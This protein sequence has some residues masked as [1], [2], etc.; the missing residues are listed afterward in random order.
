M[1]RFSMLWMMS[2]SLMA[3]YY[4]SRDVC[5]II[6]ASEVEVDARYPSLARLARDPSSYKE[7]YHMTEACFDLNEGFYMQTFLREERGVRTYS[8][9]CYYEPHAKDEG[10]VLHFIPDGQSTRCLI[11]DAFTIGTPAQNL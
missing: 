2:F 11:E 7:I 3:G 4:H 1:M 9:R 5:L 10:K 6:D 8:T